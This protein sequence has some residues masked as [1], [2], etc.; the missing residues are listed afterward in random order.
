MDGGGVPEGLHVL[1][2]EVTCELDGRGESG[3]GGVATDTDELLGRSRVVLAVQGSDDAAV[4][5]DL[6]GE[7]GELQSA[8]AVEVAGLDGGHLQVLG[9][10]V[11]PVSQLE[12]K[13]LGVQKHV[14]DAAYV[15]HCRRRVEGVEDLAQDLAERH[16]VHEGLAA[17]FHVRGAGSEAVRVIVGLL[18]EVLKRHLADQPVAALD[19]VAGPGLNKGRPLVLDEHGPGQAAAEAPFPPGQPPVATLEPQAQV[20]GHRD[21]L[22]RQ[23]PVLVGRVGRPALQQEESRLHGTQLG[24]ADDVAE[25]PDREPVQGLDVGLGELREGR[26]IVP[27]LD[28]EQVHGCQE[29]GPELAVGPR[30]LL[31][32]DLLVQDRER[33][34]HRPEVEV[35]Q[36]LAV[37][38][39]VPLHRVRVP[40]RLLVQR[41]AEIVP[42][43]ELHVVGHFPHRVRLV[44]RELVD[45]VQRDVRQEDRVVDRRRPDVEA[46]SRVLQAEC[47][48]Q[49]RLAPHRRVVADRVHVPDSDVWRRLDRRVVHLHP[50]IAALPIGTAAA[51]GPSLQPPL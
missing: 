13:R 9:K 43:H 6:G 27:P 31:Q 25:G 16:H 19:Y 18:W 21:D 32:E 3:L 22:R 35:D 29:W 1:G 23:Q 46:R 30:V 44:E 17:V 36:R 20:L 45:L 26:V 28:G 5:G 42:Q 49:Q 37:W 14:V 11:V 50:L 47:L 12:L 8:V 7:V 40:L 48:L 2:L 15:Q 39:H 34:V 24:P 38:C 33:R 10:R 4:E 41:L 51:A